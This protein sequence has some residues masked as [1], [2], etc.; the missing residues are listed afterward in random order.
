MRENEASIRGRVVM[1]L[2]AHTKNE[3]QIGKKIKKWENPKKI[4][5]AEPRQNHFAA[6]RRL[7]CR[8]DAQCIPHVCRIV[9]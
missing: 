8:C 9:Q 1:D 4:G 7:I 6:A 3:F 2:I 5:N